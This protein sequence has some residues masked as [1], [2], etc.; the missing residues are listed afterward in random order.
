MPTAW[1]NQIACIYFEQNPS[2]RRTYSRLRNAGLDPKIILGGLRSLR[3]PPYAALIVRPRAIPYAS[4]VQPTAASSK[5]SLQP[6]AAN[7][8]QSLQP[9]PASNSLESLADTELSEEPEHDLE[10]V[11][12]VVG[13]VEPEV[14]IREGAEW[15]RKESRHGGGRKAKLA[16]SR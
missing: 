3:S 14:G 4:A 1:E 7:S 8:K 16:W 6:T 9:T 11:R 13:R 12:P 5:Q 2:V 15:V 10:T